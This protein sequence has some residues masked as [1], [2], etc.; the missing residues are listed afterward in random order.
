MKKLMVKLRLN[1][2]PLCGGN[3]SFTEIEKT[4]FGLD[5]NGVRE[6]YYEQGYYDAFLECNNCHH[7]FEPDKKG[8]FFFIK[9]ELPPVK[10]STEN[11][12][13]FNPFLKY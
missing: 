7:R 1:Q 2:C 13:S 12:L 11:I 5:D 10:K 6:N 9:R 3:L 4:T 8:E